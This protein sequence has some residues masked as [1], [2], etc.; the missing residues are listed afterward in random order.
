MNYNAFMFF[1][2][3]ISLFDIKWTVLSFLFPPSLPLPLF[4][5]SIEIFFLLTY[6]IAF[7]LLSFFL[8]IFLSFPPLLAS[9]SS[10]SLSLSSTL[11]SLSSI[12][13]FHS[14]SLSAVPFDPALSEITYAKAICVLF[15]TNKEN[16]S[17]ELSER[18]EDKSTLRKCV[19]N[20]SDFKR[21]LASQIGKSLRSSGSEGG[22]GAGVHLIYYNIFISK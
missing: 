13:P 22:Q 17:S 15:Q 11:L 10:S 8:V 9:S 7:F 19:E 5:V 21:I 18:L 2:S 3:S 14:L 12:F 16:S 6:F 20:N 1:L 4:L